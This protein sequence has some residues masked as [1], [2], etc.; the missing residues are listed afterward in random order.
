MYGTAQLQ[1][2][3]SDLLTRIS[4]N[5]CTRLTSDLRAYAVLRAASMRSFCRTTNYQSFIM[6]HNNLVIVI[7]SNAH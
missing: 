2:S 4:S 5:I 1:G 7:A 6:K 3:V